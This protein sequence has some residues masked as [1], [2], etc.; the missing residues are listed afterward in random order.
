[1]DNDV[2]IT[3]IEKALGILL[4]KRQKAYILAS[5]E[6][7]YG[8][9]GSGKTTAHCIKLALS[10]GPPLN[11]DMPEKFCNF[12]YGSENNKR[13]YARSFYAHNF[14]EIRFKLAKAGF[15]VRDVHKLH[16]ANL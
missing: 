12:D 4:T 3:G 1:M 14:L 7:W 5:G 10:D 13:A 16:K 2:F 15:K 11:I 8:G 6:Y 9:R